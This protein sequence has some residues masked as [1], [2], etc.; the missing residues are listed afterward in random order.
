MDPEKVGRFSSYT[1]N[2]KPSSMIPDQTPSTDLV[3]IVFPPGR[4]FNQWNIMDGTGLC[5]TARPPKFVVFVL[6]NTSNILVTD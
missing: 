2:P 1:E 6:V 5:R 3:R 4:E